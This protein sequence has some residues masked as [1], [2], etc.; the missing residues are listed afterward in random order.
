MALTKAE[1]IEVTLHHHRE[2]KCAAITG[3][4]S[5]MGPRSL[6]TQSLDTHIVEKLANDIASRCLEREQE[7]RQWLHEAWEDEHAG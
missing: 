3:I 1:A 2:F 6:S 4:L 7:K 5:M